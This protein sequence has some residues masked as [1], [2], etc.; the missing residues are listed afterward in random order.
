M[1]VVKCI[2]MQ[3]DE[4]LLLE[5]WFRY[6]GYLFGFENL[7]IFDNG[8]TDPGVKATLARYER[9]GCEVLRS[10][11]RV[12]DFHAKGSH[13]RN[14][15]R[16]W[17]AQSRYDF[18]LPVDADEFLALFTADGLTCRREA[19]HSYLDS[20]VGTREALAFELSLFNAP[21]KPGCYAVQPY[22]KSFLAARSV[23]SLD[24][25]FH[26]ARSRL[27][28]GSRLTDLTYIHLHNKPFATLLRQ[29]R[30]KLE[31]FVDLDDP[32]TL[33]RYAGPG[34]HLV[35]YFFMTEADY[36]AQHDDQ[37]LLRFRQFGHL[38]E[39]L[40]VTGALFGDGRDEPDGCDDPEGV[41]IVSPGGSVADAVRFS[42]R[43]Y[44]HAHPDVDAAGWNP[45]HHYV[46]NG[47][48]ER[49]TAP[50]LRT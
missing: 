44:C 49:R 45:I 3:R 8:S 14:V 11:D 23:E 27:A 19:I 28:G 46:A 25:G 15:I 4:D 9:A 29:A 10:H 24:H 26:A 31:R 40:G 35:R 38:M 43:A 36:L 16:H 12:E 13:F 33:R 1:A 18:A 30:Q 42:P 39:A 21:G 32:D 20:L 48:R 34:L 2:M 7:T 37:P 50:S 17:D 41:G 5:A 22:P 6:Y 47:Y